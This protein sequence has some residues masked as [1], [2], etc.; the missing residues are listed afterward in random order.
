MVRPVVA[1]PQSSGRDRISLH[2]TT[3]NIAEPGERI[4]ATR[5]GG[6]AASSSRSQG[7]RSWVSSLLL[8]VLNEA[9]L[10][11]QAFDLHVST[12][13]FAVEIR[14]L[15]SASTA[16]RAVVSLAK[17]EYLSQGRAYGEQDLLRS[18]DFHYLRLWMVLDQ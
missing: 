2:R 15:S 14:D 7:P 12:S 3:T 1:I 18:L 5:L 13:G 16:Q 4:P 9:D 17:R 6:Q 10:S 8:H 11:A